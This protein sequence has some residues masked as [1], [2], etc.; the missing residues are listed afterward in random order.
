MNESPNTSSFFKINKKSNHLFNNSTKKIVKVKQLRLAN[1]LK[2]K[3]INKIDILKI[4]T[5]GY[6]SEVLR[7]LRGYLKFVNFIE[8]EM[9]CSDY[10]IK[11]NSFF[12]IE[13]I[14]KKDFKL[15]SIKKIVKNSSNRILWMDILYENTN[16]KFL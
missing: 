5:Q 7:G 12:E 10:Y 1:Y 13:K 4:D 11:E 3:N 6:E 16:K 2:G 14:I 8:L 15:I 9:I